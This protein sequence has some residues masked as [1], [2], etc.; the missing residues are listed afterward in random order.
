MKALVILGCGLVAGAAVPP[1]AASKATGELVS[2][3]SLLM[4]GL[5]PAMILTAT[6]LKGDSLSLTRVNSYGEALRKQLQ[7]WAVLFGAA[8]TAVLGIS[9]GKVFVEI[10]TSTTP[11]EAAYLLPARA[12]FGLAA[13]ALTHILVRLWPAYR[14]LRSILDLSIAMAATQA[15]A[16]DRTLREG[17]EKKVSRLGT[18]QRP[19]EAAWP[20]EDPQ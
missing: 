13:G 19:E 2:F 4:A 14:G 20:T 3:V 9:V 16:H 8:L 11:L 15:T 1:I 7:F 5:L 12:C 6:V 17:F 10:A 18:V